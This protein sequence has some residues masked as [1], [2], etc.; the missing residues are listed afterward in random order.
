[1]KKTTEQHL[2]D[3]RDYL[4]S[5]RSCYSFRCRRFKA[6]A[7]ALSTMGLCDADMLVDVG[8]G[9]C[10]FDYYYL[11]KTRNWRGRYVPLDGAIDG[12]N[13][14]DWN[15][16]VQPE[17]FT[18]IE[19]IEHLDKPLRLVQALQQSARKGIVL[20][21]PNPHT[22]DVL[23]MDYTHRSEVWP[24]MLESTGFAV[25]SVSLFGKPGDTL[26]ATWKRA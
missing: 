25:K 9:R 22:T 17:W 12:I 2:Q 3:C 11:R 21:T 6:V 20:T 7:D 10:D 8:A 4:S 15:P 23:G 16:T 18:A 19:F 13:L 24:F 26:L 1:M 5:R 14:E